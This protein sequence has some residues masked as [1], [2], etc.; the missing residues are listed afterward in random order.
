MALG[1]NPAEVIEDISSR[2]REGRHAA[3]A[4]AKGC[5]T[6]LGAENMLSA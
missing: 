3:T 1:G 5:D 2:I 4:R 6:V